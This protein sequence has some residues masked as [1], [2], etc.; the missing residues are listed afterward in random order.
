MEF[1]LAECWLISNR[2][3]PNKHTKSGTGALKR[4]QKRTSSRPQKKLP[5]THSLGWSHSWGAANISE[6]SINPQ[7]EASLWMD[8]VQM[9]GTHWEWEIS[10]FAEV[11]VIS[12][13]EHSA[14]CSPTSQSSIYQTLTF[15][16][17]SL[18][19]SW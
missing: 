4:S 17:P 19:S 5:N 16:F 12:H 10:L 18:S 1:Y 7:M 9:S 6:P 14:S 8:P 11:L 13:T 3:E 2:L 15:Y